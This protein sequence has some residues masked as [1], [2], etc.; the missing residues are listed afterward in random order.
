MNNKITVKLLL[1]TTIFCLLPAYFIYNMGANQL[2]IPNDPRFTFDQEFATSSTTFALVWLF[3]GAIVFKCSITTYDDKDINENL[4]FINSSGNSIE[5]TEIPK[6]VS[7]FYT[8]IERHPK[9]S[10]PITGIALLGLLY[11]MLNTIYS[12]IVN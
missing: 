8:L 9:I 10:M 3:I 11:F 2:V 6:C 4:K 12:F 5:P 7:R 1:K